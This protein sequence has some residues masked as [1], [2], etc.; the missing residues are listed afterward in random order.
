MTL[1]RSGAR[2][3][4]MRSR[5]LRGSLEQLEN[6]AA[7]TI[8]RCFRGWQARADMLLEWDAMQAR[9]DLETQAATLIQA[10]HRGLRARRQLQNAWSTPLSSSAE[11]SV[12]FDFDSE[13]TRGLTL[14]QASRYTEAVAAFELCHAMRPDASLPPYY[15]AGCL[16]AMSDIKNGLKWLD[17]AVLL[18]MDINELMRDPDLKKLRYHPELEVH[19][20]S[21]QLRYEAAVRLQAVARGGLT[22][23]KLEREMWE[24]VQE[25]A[26]VRVQAAVRGWD[27]RRNL[28]MEREAEYSYAKMV[29]LQGFWRGQLCRRKLAR[30][31]EAVTTIAAY[32]RMRVLRRMF[33]LIQRLA[34]ETSGVICIQRIWRGTWL[35]KEF[36]SLRE[37]AAAVVAQSAYRGW[38]ARKRLAQE[39]EHE[40][41][42]FAALQIQSI[43]R[44]HSKRKDLLRQMRDALD[45]LDRE[46]ATRIQAAYRSWAAR[47]RLAAE[48]RLVK[49]QAIWRGAMAR[50][51]LELE[52][53]AARLILE[54]EQA[55]TTIQAAFRGWSVRATIE[56][57]RC[58]ASLVS[59]QAIRRGTVARQGVG[60]M[61]LR[62]LQ[63]RER[64][65][66]KLA[67]QR[68]RSETGLVK[69]QARQ[70]GRIARRLH[71]SQRQIEAAALTLQVLLRTIEP[72]EE[73]IARKLRSRA[74]MESTLSLQAVEEMNYSR[75][76]PP[77]QAVEAVVQVAL[78]ITEAAESAATRS[79]APLQTS[80]TPEETFC[81]P[82]R[83]ETPPLEP[84]L[85]EE[86][87]TIVA[88]E[89][90]SEEQSEHESEHESEQE[91]VVPETEQEEVVL[92]TEQVPDDKTTGAVPDTQAIVLPTPDPNDWAAL[93]A[94]E[95]QQ[96][97]KKGDLPSV[98]A[99]R[100]PRSGPRKKKQPV[101]QNP[102][103][104]TAT[105]GGGSTAGP[106]TMRQRAKSTPGPVSGVLQ[107]EA[108]AGYDAQGDLPG[109]W[110]AEAQLPRP[111][112]AEAQRPRTSPDSHQSDVDGAILS[113]SENLFAPAPVDAV[114]AGT[115]TDRPQ[116]LSQNPFDAPA[117]PTSTAD[118]RAQ[119]AGGIGGSVR[120]R[121]HPGPSQHL[122]AAAN[123]KAYL[124]AA[125]GD[126]AH[127]TELALELTGSMMA[128]LQGTWSADATQ[129]R[130]STAGGT[131]GGSLIYGPRPRTSPE[132][133]PRLLPGNPFGS[134]ASTSSS[135]GASTPAS[136]KVKKT[137]RSQ[138]TPG[139]P[140]SAMLRLPDPAEQT[141]G[142][143]GSI[144][145]T[146]SA[147][148]EAPRAPL[149]RQPSSAA[150]KRE[151]AAKGTLP[152]LAK[153]RGRQR[154]STSDGGTA[155]KPT[156]ASSNLEP[157]RRGR[158][159]TRSEHV[160][161][162]RGRGRSRSKSRSRG[163]G[164]SRG[165]IS[166]AADSRDNLQQQRQ[167]RQARPETPEQ[168]LA[169]LVSPSELNASLP[170]RRDR[171]IDP[172]EQ[173]GDALAGT[174]GHISP[175][176]RRGATG[177][178]AGN[179]QR[180][181]R[182]RRNSGR[183]VQQR[184][185]PRGDSDEEN[186]PFVKS[187]AKKYGS[188]PK[189]PLPPQKSEEK[190]EKQQQQQQ[191]QQE[192]EEDAAGSVVLAEI[193]EQERKLMGALGMKHDGRKHVP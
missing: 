104:P 127:E 132:R 79:L 85:A 73:L 76:S 150:D 51:K 65:E 58:L 191:Q 92:E 185:E 95:Q 162:P 119:S 123:I 23:A 159:S 116:A 129:V 142:E 46:M 157:Q 131:S 10:A 115:R 140:V 101:E 60:R 6:D 165:P 97:K 137:Q 174:W 125:E 133:Q 18:G 155:S 130:A 70:R 146:W 27:T 86:W 113:W 187:L 7:T 179:Q 163:R 151:Q 109:T 24:E 153:G 190:Q 36:Q 88:A 69:L 94:R 138:S 120:S 47:R 122:E 22:R 121:S 178:G 20:G 147:E 102:F 28:R 181:A 164:Q 82:P 100:P 32:Q 4:S 118:R 54:R 110:S 103:G 64:M 8:Q 135:S 75:E 72:R 161:P 9:H 80:K 71:P 139:S 48:Q 59:M 189:D 114:T 183:V 21:A 176:S 168:A 1:M 112:A 50:R 41:H 68:K 171:A 169:M 45:E 16:S 52:L 26:A 143:G 90:Q 126:Q 105:L 99:G 148:A 136:V 149:A 98:T 152:S 83:P 39:Y 180:A 57:E 96:N 158:G 156:A 12:M 172:V 128:Q 63:E 67:S 33:V 167:Q 193:S 182:R 38:A 30:Q 177:G 44:G 49:L 108:S 111:S 5:L 77:R 29:K 53:E 37:Q 93:A 141:K 3:T 144:D 184:W 43:W 17:I 160:T 186:I 134:S 31:A 13:L 173:L 66:I 175:R 34:L 14:M 61:Q 78:D 40:Q 192:E 56:M 42:E 62:E 74:A 19:Y 11:L 166:R 2:A 106:A 188:P 15:L 170:P 35:R 107:L 145:G 154:P 89:E 84:L 91:E 25:E 55:A 117:G 124:S 87:E 81:P